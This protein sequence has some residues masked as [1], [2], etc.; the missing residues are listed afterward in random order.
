MNEMSVY[1]STV[2]DGICDTHIVV[3][4]PFAIVPEASAA[5]LHGLENSTCHEFLFGRLP[6]HAAGWN[7]PAE[8]WMDPASQNV[9][10]WAAGVVGVGAAV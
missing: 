8:K 2:R 10:T 7:S 6:G 3:L 9:R 4:F 1:H 5:T